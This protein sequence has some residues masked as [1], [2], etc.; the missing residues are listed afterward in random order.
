[1][2]SPSN[3][4]YADIVD[5]VYPAYVRVLSAADDADFMGFVAEYTT[6]SAEATLND[7]R[8]QTHT[9]HKEKSSTPRKRRAGARV[10][11][12]ATLASR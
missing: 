6:P 4:E 5:D 11:R 10:S 3:P 8:A 9:L 7:H 1:M 2:A 12:L